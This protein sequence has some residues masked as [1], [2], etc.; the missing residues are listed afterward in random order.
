MCEEKEIV[1]H[2]SNY[3]AYFELAGLSDHNVIVNT[4][5]MHSEVDSLLLIYLLTFEP[6]VFMYIYLFLPAK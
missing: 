4:L 3:A 2:H 1:T 5:Y 6:A